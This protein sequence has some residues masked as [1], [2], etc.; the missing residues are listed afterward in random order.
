MWIKT[1]R[2]IKRLRNEHTNGKIVEFHDNGTA[3]VTEEIGQSLI[4]EYEHVTTRNS[5]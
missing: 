3:Q 1:T 5:N 2:P 4:E